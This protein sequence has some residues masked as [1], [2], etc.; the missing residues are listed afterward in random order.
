MKF[1]LSFG[2]LYVVQQMVYLLFCTSFEHVC[3]MQVLS[4]GHTYIV[5]NMIF[6][7]LCTKF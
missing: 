3:V 7:E 6:L 5:Q 2:W 4:L 1:A